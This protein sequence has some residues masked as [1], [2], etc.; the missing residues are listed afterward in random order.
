MEKM[1]LGK[2]ILCV[3]LICA[4]L[5]N[6]AGC[7][8]IGIQTET[9][10]PD[11]NAKTENLTAGVKANKVDGRGPDDKFISAQ[12]DFAV[13]LF[14]NTYSNGENTLISPLSVMLA[15]AMTANGAGNKTRTEMEKL[16]G[17]GSPIEDLNE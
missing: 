13:R 16:L 2:L 15:L 10:T 1:Y 8:V 11:P 17:G 3:S 12:A 5:L 4:M 9:W 14:Q 6:F 7:A